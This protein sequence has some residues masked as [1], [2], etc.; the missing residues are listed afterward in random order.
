MSYTCGNPPDIVP[1]FAKGYA[2]PLYSP[3][4]LPE[5]V[6]ELFPPGVDRL[7][8]FGKTVGPGPALGA[9]QAALCARLARIPEQVDEAVG[10]GWLPGDGAADALRGLVARCAE[11][12]GERSAADTAALLREL[13]AATRRFAAMDPPTATPEA[14]ALFALTPGLIAERLEGLGDK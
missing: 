3:Q 7:G 12:C 13:E 1:C 10:L 14:E 2:P 5:H 9:D 4:E 8:L 11:G 6:S